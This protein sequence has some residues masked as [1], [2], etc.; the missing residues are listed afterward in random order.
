VPSVISLDRQGMGLQPSWSWRASL[1]RVLAVVALV[2]GCASLAVGAGESLCAPGEAI[3]F[4]CA[5]GK[6]TASVCAAQE[7]SAHKGYLQYRFG[8]KAAPEIVL[9][10]TIA[11]PPAGVHGKTLS[12]AGGGGAY[13]RFVSGHYSYIVYT[14][15]RRGI[16]STAGIAVERDDRR[17]A[18]LCCTGLVSSEIGPD[19]FGKAGLPQDTRDFD[20][21]EGC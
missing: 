12:F 1:K 18:S 3:I 4:S 14:A 20:I 13:L 21:P 7:I 15:V 17:I 10:N 9:P 8:R 16:G 5:I 2:A 19:F 6:K 11:L